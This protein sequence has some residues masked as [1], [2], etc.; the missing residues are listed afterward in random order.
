MKSFSLLTVFLSLV[1]NC[2]S[3]PIRPLSSVGGIWK[4]C[5]GKNGTIL[6][7]NGCTKLLICY[8]SEMATNRKI[9]KRIGVGKGTI[10]KLKF[11][12]CAEEI[13]ED[14][15]HDV[16][17]LGNELQEAL[18]SAAFFDD[19]MPFVLAFEFGA[20]FCAKNADTAKLCKE[21]CLTKAPFVV[22]PTKSHG[23]TT[24][25]SIPT[26]TERQTFAF[27]EFVSHFGTNCS[28]I[29]FPVEVAKF[30]LNITAVPYRIACNEYEQEYEIGQFPTDY[31]ENANQI[32]FNACMAVPTTKCAKHT[33]LS[34]C[35]K[36]IKT[37]EPNDNAIAKLCQDH[38]GEANVAGFAVQICIHRDE[39]E[40]KLIFETF[41]NLSTTDE[42][43]KIT[44]SFT[45][46]IEQI[47]E[48][49]K[50]L[51][52]FF[53]EFGTDQQK[54]S[55]R[56]QANGKVISGALN[57]N[58]N[59][60]GTVLNDIKAE[61]FNENL[62]KMIHLVPPF[63][64]RMKA[65]F[66]IPMPQFFKLISAQTNLKPYENDPKKVS[67]FC[68]PKWV[69]IPPPAIPYQNATETLVCYG[70][71]FCNKEMLQKDYD[72]VR[73]RCGLKP[74][75]L[76]SR[77]KRQFGPSRGA[78]L[79][80][81]TSFPIVIS[82]ME[83]ALPE[84]YL[85]W[86]E[87]IKVGT[88]MIM[89]HT[90]VQFKIVNVD[91]KSKYSEGILIRNVVSPKLHRHFK[92]CL[93]GLSKVGKDGGWQELML[94]MEHNC[95]LKPNMSGVACH[96]LLHALGNVHEQSRSDARNFVIFRDKNEQSLIYHDTENFGFDYDFGSVLHDGGAYD[97][98]ND[99]YDRITLPRFYQQTIGQHER[100]S[101]KDAAIINQIYCKDSCKGHEDKC[102]NG[103]YLNPND[104]TKCHCP[105]G[106]GG[107]NCAALEEN[108]NCSIL[109]NESMELKSDQTA[110]VLK[111][112]IGCTSA[113]K[114]CRCHWRITAN[115]YLKMNN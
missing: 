24:T 91:E 104:C 70:D 71:L 102:Q 57:E 60:I 26:I 69:D 51:P 39:K 112:M 42:V 17:P 73:Q 65:F 81:W 12:E 76:I 50:T 106:Y 83:N 108:E 27:A 110:K 115:F 38:L 111:P 46:S 3:P 36:S 79:G 75:N 37:V 44:R 98:R 28:K 8:Q 4:T 20:K 10:G 52:I 61:K 107:Q 34:A 88:N 94:A 15:W 9:G 80:K 78:E 87:A 2:S 47:M 74:E 31:V 82:F 92:N 56:E 49:K 6:L 13:A 16:E 103:G 5:N 95:Y 105:D 11:V 113:D 43:I 55:I 1:I 40:Q 22:G 33:E 29:V 18:S 85:A 93:L 67:A 100:I 48:T 97:E 99:Q 63:A 68:L 96:E 53:L 89:Q 66:Q 59:G 21:K 14:Q 114:E 25:T 54:S 30:I 77:R 90:C 23:K 32:F 41:L 62:A 72:R 84:K 7:E 109:S 101:F 35:Y 86:K 58:A 45:I 64:D 19:F